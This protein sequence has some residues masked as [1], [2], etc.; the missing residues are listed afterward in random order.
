M[1]TST[2]RKS[3]SKRDGRSRKGSAR[4]AQKPAERRYGCE[5]P[6]IFTPPLRELTPETS[7][8]F[9]VIEFAAVIGIDLF[10]WQRWLLIH[11]LELLQ[12]GTLR[13]GTVV[14]LVARQNGKSALSQVL[15]LWIM[16]ALDWPVV[17]GTA[18]DIDTAEKV[19]SGAVDLLESDEELAPLIRKV[20]KTNG[21]KSL[22]LEAFDEDGLGGNEYRVKSANRR[23]GRGFSGN[24][25]LLDELR[26]HQNWFAW[27]AITHTTMAQLL[28]L[29]V[30]LSNAGDATSVVLAYFR[31]AAHRALGDPDGICEADDALLAPTEADLGDDFEDDFIDEVLDEIDPAEHLGFFEW[32]APPGMDRRNRDGWAQANPSM[33]HIPPLERNIAQALAEPE[34]VF[35]TEVLC[36]WPDGA[37]DGPFL[38]G[39]W[40]KGRNTPVEDEHGR[41]VPAAKDRLVGKT[42]A[43]VDTAFSRSMTYI[44][45]CGLRADGVHQVE[46]RAARSGQEWVKDWL[47][48]RADTIHSVTGQSRG[49]P[50]SK[51]MK[52]LAADREFAARIPV[53][54]WQGG[55]LA[56]ATDEA[57]YAVKDAKV[58]HN[59]QPTLDIAATASATKDWG[60]Q[61]VIDRKASPV[62]A[63]PLV[64]FVG[65]LWLARR[66]VQAAPPPPPPPELVTAPS[67]SRG[68]REANLNDVRF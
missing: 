29:I 12:D 38:P 1:T 14:V 53:V 16:M 18:Q 24:L 6:R 8:G 36:Q 20:N 35:R 13:F 40:E 51:L 3:P 58:R 33:G 37:V 17:L 10:P 34:W 65:A 7:L 21:K 5:V 19:W 64:A 60:D 49:A 57:W 27:A 23:A 52:D 2:R 28:K 50:V 39:S 66:K 22:I 55:D 42:W 44:A 30:C 62:D 48:E 59:P 46:I 25:I 15:A 54:D 63:A 26:E 67:P 31:K 61:K 45:L 41:K 11:M 68:T 47:L 32:S 43:C 4:T 9:S 56:G